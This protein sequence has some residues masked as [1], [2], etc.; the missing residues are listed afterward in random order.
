MVGEWEG[1]ESLI[2]FR[3]KGT[4]AFV[5]NEVMMGPLPRKRAHELCIEARTG[6]QGT[7]PHR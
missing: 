4:A 5:V 3:W 2:H 6:F 7:Q 1:Q